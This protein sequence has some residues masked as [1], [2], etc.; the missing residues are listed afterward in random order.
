MAL[1]SNINAYF[2]S[3]LVI[4]IKQYYV[5]TPSQ[6]WFPNEAFRT[7]FRIRM[8]P[9]KI[10]GIDHALILHI[11]KWLPPKTISQCIDGILM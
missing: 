6:K 5:C 3:C 1:H 10:V 7:Y 8:Y 4:E 9:L 2:R 11:T